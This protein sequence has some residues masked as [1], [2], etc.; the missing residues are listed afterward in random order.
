MQSI[1]RNGSW[2]SHGGNEWASKGKHSPLRVSLPLALFPPDPRLTWRGS[3]FKASSVRAHRSLPLTRTAPAFS[4]ASPHPGVLCAGRLRGL[5]ASP[6]A[7]R[8]AP[9]PRSFPEGL[10]TQRCLSTHRIRFPPRLFRLARDARLFRGPTPAAVLS[11]AR[12]CQGLSGALPMRPLWA[13]ALRAAGGCAMP[14]VQ[15]LSGVSGGSSRSAPPKAAQCLPSGVSA[16]AVELEGRVP[17]G[18]PRGEE[19]AA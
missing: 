17:S 10:Q 11:L 18:C 16:S 3:H 15:V 7:L 12:S 1:R 6:L 5:L 4:D 2:I 9:P 8:E 13:A 14:P 19:P